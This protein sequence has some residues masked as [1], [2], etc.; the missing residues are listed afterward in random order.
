MGSS[1]SGRLRGITRRDFVYL[2][3]AGAAGA[4]V[5][6][7]ADSPGGTPLDRIAGGPPDAWSDA[8]G[9]AWYGP[10][11]VGDYAP[12]HGNTPDV[13]RL[14]HG[15]R[16]DRYAG[17]LADAS[18][19]GERFDVV[20]VGGG[21]A[22]LSA[23]HHFKRHHPTGRCLVLDNHPIFGGEAKRNEFDVGGVRLMGPQGS[24]DFVA[25]AGD[26]GPDDYFRSLGIPM[27]FEY[28]PD[29]ST[30]LRVP[31]EN[32][33]FMHWV[34]DR[35]SVGHRLG[36][37]AGGED[38]FIRD[39]WGAGLETAPWSEEVKAGFRRWRDAR[40]ADHAPPDVSGQDPPRWLDG[41]TLKQYYEGVLGLP[42]QVTAYVDPILASIIGLGCD[43]VSAWWGY[44]FALPGFGVPS[45]YDDV[46]F[47]SFP[48]GNAGIA[49]YFM[50]DLVPDSIPGDGSL[51]DMVGAE[52]RFDELDRAGGT[53]AVR[54]SATVVDVRHF[55]P[56]QDR[57]RVT[58][59]LG[60]RLYSVE[61]SGVVMAS[62]GWVNRHV[63]PELPDSHRHAYEQFVHAPILVANVALTN[64][65]FME[66]LGVAACMYEGDLGFS[67]NI[68]RPMYTPS[69]RPPFGPD[70]PNVLTFYITF[71]SP[72]LAP[73]DQG[74]AGRTEMLSTSFADYERRLV[75][76]MRTLFDDGGFDA[77]SDIAGIVLNRWGHAYLAPGPGFFF[78][79]N[80]APAPPDVIRQ[81][82]G[83]IAIGHSELRGHQNW[84]GAAGEGRRAVETLLESL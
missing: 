60:D 9:V 69:Y 27:E 65:R 55:G 46:V 42:P 30:D 43:A 78:G 79:T 51:G 20:I 38:A 53:V 21:L 33:G 75:D 22:G 39:L 45:R 18:D 72:G 17:Q 63:L 80:P 14:A 11:G 77:G 81:P 13:V 4:V 19:T 61:A 76:Q 54:L 57:V 68:R 37:V 66:R 40:L 10:G 47:Q 49:R 15:L 23:A 36:G 32:Y 41:I 34:Q 5:S 7:R 74:I 25:R 52:V 31:L 50:K 16:V 26:G 12:S 6:C 73:G 71:E 8:L 1:D 28:A 44:H 83:R 58:Y 84:T 59:A 82:L 29:D 24:N 70:H 2:A 3:G 62:G 67:C 56:A 35:F 48:G 64:W